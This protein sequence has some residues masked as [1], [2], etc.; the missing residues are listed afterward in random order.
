MKFRSIII[1]AQA[2]IY[3]FRYEFSHFSP[4]QIRQTNVY[5]LSFPKVSGQSKFLYNDNTRNF[6]KYHISFVAAVKIVISTQSKRVL[7]MWILLLL[8]LNKNSWYRQQVQ[9]KLYTII[10]L[11]STSTYWDIFF[12]LFCQL[13][14]NYI[15][16]ATSRQFLSLQTLVCM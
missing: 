16:K 12:T 15:I 14:I 5:L 7:Q 3:V 2:F 10:S 4:V 6:F 8:H 11:L 13:Q 9:S 1:V